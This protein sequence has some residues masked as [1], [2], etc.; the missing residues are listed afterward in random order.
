MRRETLDVHFV[1]DQLFEIQIRRCRSPP[2]EC[3]VDHDG[4]GHDRGIVTGIGSQI[5][6]PGARIVS[7][8]QIF[9]VAE[10]SRDRFCIWVE[11]QLCVIESPAPLR[12]V[13]ST[14]FVAVELARLQALN[15]DVPYVLV[16]VRQLDDVGRIPVGTDEQQQIRRSGTPRIDRKVDTLCRGCGAERK[17]RALVDDFRCAVCEWCRHTPSE[18]PG[19][20]LISQQIIAR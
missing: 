6:P 2:V 7:E 12:P 4:L 18:R 19:L 17:V 8:Q 1:D 9:D 14:H 16:S 15:E 11:Q 13:V 20:Q 3:V 10:L 5:S